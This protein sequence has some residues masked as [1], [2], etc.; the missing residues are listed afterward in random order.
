MANRLGAL[1]FLNQHGV[2]A[3]LLD[4]Y[5][6]GDWRARGECPK[7]IAGW[8]QALDAQD[9]H[10]ALPSQHPLSSRI[11]RMFLPVNS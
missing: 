8:Q 4:I 9:R 10:I 6:C 1:W 11:H 7:D 2:K 5:F 3:T